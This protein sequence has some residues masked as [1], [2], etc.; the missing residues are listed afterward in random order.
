M[1]FFG[2]FVVGFQGLEEDVN[3]IDMA[4]WNL[5]IPEGTPSMTI[6]A[7]MLQQGYQDSYFRTANGGVVFW[8]PVTGSST[9]QSKF[10]RSELRESH[11]DGSPRN[12]YFPAADNLLRAALSINKV[13]SSGRIIIGQVHVNYGPAP[14]LTLEYQYR[15]NMGAV[16]AKIRKQPRDRYPFKVVLATGLPLDQRFTYSIH[17]TPSG[18]LSISSYGAHWAG[19]L[20]AVWRTTPLYFKAGVYTLDNTGYTNE[21]GQATFYRIEAKHL[22]PKSKPSPI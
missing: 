8:A 6:A 12:W 3:V 11:A 18:T 20:D 21:G 16:V 19:R 13:P 5:T 2:H 10:P 4:A 15:N 7:P 1:L 9:P 17:L 22:P 14:L